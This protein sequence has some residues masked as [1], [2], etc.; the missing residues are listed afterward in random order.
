MAIFSLTIQ[1]KGRKTEIV[2][3]V[4]IFIIQLNILVHSPRLLRK[5]LRDKSPLNVFP[6]C[7]IVFR[8]GFLAGSSHHQISTLLNY[9]NSKHSNLRIL[10][11]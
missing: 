4:L 1:T 2:L 6:K 10:P 8:S 11:S 3:H 5:G 9:L 7:F